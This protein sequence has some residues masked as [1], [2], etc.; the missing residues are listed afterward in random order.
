M[1]VYVVMTQ[2]GW[3]SDHV[4]VSGVYKNKKDAIK[5]V[6]KFYNDIFEHDYGDFKDL[7]RSD[8]IDDVN[9]TGTCAWIIQRTVK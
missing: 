8:L 4:D 1:K 2:V 7:K 5:I 3:D 9:S 6:N